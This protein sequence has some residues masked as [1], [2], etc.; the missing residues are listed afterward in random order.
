MVSLTI[1]HEYIK[2]HMYERRYLKATAAYSSRHTCIIT[3]N[4]KPIPIHEHQYLKATDS[5]VESMRVQLSGVTVDACGYAPG[6]VCSCA[7]MCLCMH[8]CMVD[9]CAHVCVHVCTHV[10]RMPAVTL[11]SRFV[12]VHVHVYLCMH[13]CVFVITRHA[14]MH[15]HI[16]IHA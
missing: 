15:I 16:C 2:I 3:D 5:D 14:Q 7:C 13:A 12:V 9:A 1:M 6:Q 11:Q 8:T 4:L 10:W